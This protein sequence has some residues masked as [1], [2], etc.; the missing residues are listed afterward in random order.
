MHTTKKT[1]AAAALAAGVMMTG[2]AYAQKVDVTGPKGVK[3]SDA[4]LQMRGDRQARAQVRA[5]NRAWNNLRAQNRAWNNR[6]WHGQHA[7]WSHPFGWPGAAV[8]GAGYAAGTVAGAALG[9]AGNIVGAPFGYNTYAY[10]PNGYGAFAA[11]GY[12]YVPEY[13]SAGYQITPG[14]VGVDPV[15]PINGAPANPCSLNLAQLNRC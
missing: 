5:Q 11:S 2:T 9:T 6:G 1:V 3:S 13:D 4:T 12:G 7:G 15:G 10:A 8:A 14:T